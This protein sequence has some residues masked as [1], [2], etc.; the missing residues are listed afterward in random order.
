MWIPQGTGS[1]NVVVPNGTEVL[2]SYWLPG[3]GLPVSSALSSFETIPGCDR[4]GGGSGSAGPGGGF[5]GESCDT[6]A[7]GA[8]TWVVEMEAGAFDGMIC[9]WAL[10]SGQS[11]QD[12]AC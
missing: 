1:V 6:P 9:L 3:D 2:R 8:G 11:P 12:W 10:P 4:N 5:G 7:L